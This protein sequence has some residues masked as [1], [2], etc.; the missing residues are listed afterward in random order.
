MYHFIGIKGSGMASLATI[1]SDLG[2]FVQGSD[3]EKHFFTEVGLK[4]RNIKI[5]T[6]NENNIVD[7][8]TIIKGAS[9]KSDNP[10]L[11][12]AK[13]LGLEILEYNEMVGKL[14]N[15]FKTICVCGCHG[16]TTT[17]TMLSVGLGKELKMNYLIGDGTGYAN[18]DNEFFALESCEYQR[19][20]LEYNPFYTIIT[21]IDLD[22]VD[23]FK[24]IEDV[25]DAYTEFA[26]KTKKLIIACGDDENTR[27]I[28]V[29]KDIVF[30]GFNSDNNIRAVNLEF[31]ESGSKFDV[32]IDNFMYGHFELPLYGEHQVL[33]A[34]AVIALSY[35]EG[36]DSKVVN[37][38]LSKFHG[39]KRR[40]SITE[41]KD[42]VVIDDYAH[43]PSEVNSTINSVKQ[44]YKDK[45][46]VIIFQPHTFSRTKEFAD[47][48]V[49]IFK[50]VDYSYILDIFPAREK[51][52]DYP[53]IT[54][55]IITNKL[56]NASIITLDDAKI[57]SKHS[58]TV[59]VFMS[60][61]DISKLENELKE[62]L[63]KK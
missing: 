3:I 44:K 11:I 42:S 21:N 29:E 49:E 31:N 41:I 52:E 26:N 54:S 7:G 47:D 2:Y 15:M 33:D 24:G 6:Y 59:F 10:E 56:D 39:A 61:N 8:L 62:I 12:K 5:F 16:K 32:I 37:D 57:L 38:N 55:R 46:I 34:L 60:P 40:F 18:R 9:I 25:I 63:N 48:F 35:Y 13:E 50:N 58:N 20:F 45:K 30:Y 1:L 22:H 36:I 28:K 17:T 14:T 51:Q 23:Y 43:H 27:N 4:E 19:H 53:G